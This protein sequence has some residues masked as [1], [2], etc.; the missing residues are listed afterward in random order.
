MEKMTLSEELSW[1]GLV[2]QTTIHNL[3]ELD[4]SPRTF[5]HGYDASADSQTIGNLA[6][7][8][9][10][11]LF[12]RHG[13]KAVILAGGATSLIGDPGGK[14]AERPMQSPDEVA[15]NIKRAIE[16]LQGI[17]AG[18]EVKF[19]NNLDWIKSM[20]VIEFLRDIGKH[21]SMTPLLQRDYIAQRIG[22][23]GNGISYTEFSYTLLQ[24]LDY[25]HLFDHEGVTVQLGGSDQWGNCLSGVELVRK[26]RGKEVHVVS[27]PL[28][29]NRSTGKKF[30]K[31]EA[32]AIWLD[33]QK[34]TVYDFYQFWLNVDDESVEEY[35]KKFTEIG[36]AELTQLMEEFNTDKGGRGA[37]K[38]LAYEVT[39]IVHG[40]PAAD[41]ARQGSQTLF[42]K[43]NYDSFTAEDFE[44]L[45]LS[46]FE[47]PVGIPL[48][49]ALVSSGLAASNTEAR[50]FLQDGAIYINDSPAGAQKVALTEPDFIAGYLVL[51]RGKNT[52][53]LVKRK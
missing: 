53:V 38:T 28:L 9:M 36:K 45:H 42:N 47:L 23:E 16:Q 33:A 21:F 34:T 39:K 4:V 18:F 37:Q 41:Q 48:V 51:R 10:D 25:L 6:A 30:G 8:M 17:L 27:H 35:L 15:E 31:S 26:V 46:Q 13:W 50:R 11:R 43:P 22:P 52:Q 29:V 32:G 49:N 14:D 1:R 24:G 20:T 5:Y 2:E 3:A 12:L 44:K 40:A 19:V 7:M